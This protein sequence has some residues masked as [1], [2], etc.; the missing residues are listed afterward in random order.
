L[1]QPIGLMPPDEKSFDLAFFTSP[2]GTDCQIA[3][4]FRD[5]VGARGVDGVTAS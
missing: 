4:S 3:V 1:D 2:D 5:A